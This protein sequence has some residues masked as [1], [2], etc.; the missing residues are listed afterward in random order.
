MDCIACLDGKN[1]PDLRELKPPFSLE[2]DAQNDL[3]L[4]HVS[5]ALRQV[6][7]KANLHPLFGPLGIY[8]QLQD[9]MNTDCRD[10]LA[11]GSCA[12]SVALS[13]I[14]SRQ[15]ETHLMNA[16]YDMCR[17]LPSTVGVLGGT[18]IE[19]QVADLLLETEHCYLGYG[20]IFTN[21]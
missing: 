9:L 13:V 6:I 12:E 8:S 11:V 20:R 10:F 3:S 7:P 1:L 17:L 19:S 15:D 18:K 16:D 21:T 14:S 5:F 2:W 4:V